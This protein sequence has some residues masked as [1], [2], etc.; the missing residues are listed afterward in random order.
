MMRT[1]TCG[2]LRTEHIGQTVRLAGW[3]AS[4]RDHGGLVFVDV[5]DREGITQVVF[6]PN[7]APEAHALAH[8]LRAE[9]VVAVTG[10]AAPRPREAVKP[11]L[12][13]GEVE[14]R[15]SGLEVLNPARTPPFAI[16]GPGPV[17]EA[18]RLRYR[19]LDLR[20][21]RMQR[22]LQ[23]RH[24]MTRAV[25]DYLDGRGFIEVETPLLIR[26]TPEGARD[27]VVPA[28]NRPGHFFAL[29]Q[30][31][32]LLKQLLMVSGFE[33]YYQ[34]ARCL[35][36]EDLRADRQPE[37]TQIDI[38]MSFVDEDDVLDLS[39]ELTRHVFGAVGI[40]IPG[41]FRR[42]S[43]REAMER[44][45]SDRPDTRFGLELIA[46]EEAF[47]KTKFR[48]FARAMAEGGVIRGLRVPA[49]ANGG[50]L[51]RQEL[52][53]LEREV[54]QA[55]AKGLAWFQIGTEEETRGPIVK[56]LSPEERSRL[57]ELTSAEP[58]DLVLVVA[59]SFPA[60]CL[61]L[62]RIRVQL[63]R[64]L[65]LI[66]SSLWHGLRVSSFPLYEFDPV[67]NRITPM[68]HPFSMPHAQD[69]PYL[70]SDPL[71][72]R[73]RVYD[74]VLN[75]VEIASGSIR[76]HQR[77]VQEK[78]LSVIQMPREEAEK[79]FGFLLEAFQ[80]GAPPHGGIA[81]GFDRMVAMACGEESIRDVI[82]FPKNAAGADTMMGAPSEVAQEQLEELHIALRVPPAMGKSDA[83]QDSQR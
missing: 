82:A 34:M 14:V 61:A 81:F 28:R 41:P 64:Q 26:S 79:R 15:A 24:Q 54:R 57:R 66:N 36:D 35:R 30:S 10:V 43:Y 60:A 49:E 69:L 80:Y 6:D 39:E 32:Q 29:P 68:H 42:L 77:E 65:G 16:D 5:R 72:V 21:R 13:T 58:G 2:E 20:T 12:P 73:G 70:D 52:E 3:V 76:I 78:V 67:E 18:V 9:F 44:Y 46:L 22:N 83:G 45:G 8:T 55:G 48:G 23:V 53:K 33:R 27:Y 17:E 7:A 31:P 11:D 47:A 4:A 75:G 71:R 74:L 59:D 37:F 51:P 38:E 1:H 62:G 50:S 25:R 63:G 19:Y 56:F 40:R